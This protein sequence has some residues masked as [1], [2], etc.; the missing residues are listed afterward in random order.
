MSSSL[1]DSPEVTALDDPTDA[2]S[3][4]GRWRKH[5]RSFRT[6]QT[7]SVV[8]KHF[9]AE[10]SHLSVREHVMINLAENESGDLC[11]KK[12]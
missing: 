5:L 8:F 7:S 9:N 12:Y 4:R 11:F 2:A 6:Q 1:L 10:F 3:P